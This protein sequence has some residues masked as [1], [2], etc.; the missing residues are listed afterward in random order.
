MIMD[1]KIDMNKTGATQAI[2]VCY[3]CRK[4]YDNTFVRVLTQNKN[5]NF[6][7]WCLT[8][9]CKKCAMFNELKGDEHTNLL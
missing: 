6:G 9:M 5:K 4:E 2:I 7:G 3:I 1:V 8:Y